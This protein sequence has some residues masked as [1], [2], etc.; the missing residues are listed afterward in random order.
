MRKAVCDEIEAALAPACVFT[1]P[2]DSR[3][4]PAWPPPIEHTQEAKIFR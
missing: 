2:S 4:I 3:A 1:A